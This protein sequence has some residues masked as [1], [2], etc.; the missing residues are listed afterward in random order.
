MQ[1]RIVLIHNWCRSL[2]DQKA[3]SV[4]GIHYQLQLWEDTSQTFSFQFKYFFAY[5]MKVCVILCIY[6]NKLHLNRLFFQC[7]N[8]LVTRGSYCGN[9]VIYKMCIKKDQ[10][11]HAISVYDAQVSAWKH[12]KAPLTSRVSLDIIKLWDWI[13]MPIDF[14]LTNNKLISLAVAV[15]N[16]ASCQKVLKCLKQTCPSMFNFESLWGN[17]KVSMCDFYYSLIL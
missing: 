12:C 13:Y 4:E 2:V 1:L 14:V 17:L 15:R 16:I 7:C 6:Q 8:L 9:D 11:P 10:L 3:Y 5:Y